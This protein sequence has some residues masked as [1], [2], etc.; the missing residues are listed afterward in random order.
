MDFRVNY[1]VVIFS[2]FFR[3]HRYTFLGIHYASLKRLN[4][5]TKKTV[6]G[7][8]S[9]GG[10]MKKSIALLFV[11]ALVAACSI[12][13]FGIPT[14]STIFK[15]NVI[16]DTYNATQ[17]ADEDSSLVVQGGILTLHQ[18]MNE[19]E[20]I[21]FSTD[22]VINSEI[23]EIGEISIDDPAPTGTAIALS[24]IDPN[25]SNGFVPAPGI[26]AFTMPVIL[27]D[28][29]EPLGEFQNV[30]V[31]SGTATLSFINNTVIWLGNINNGEPLVIRLLDSDGNEIL[32][33]TFDQDVPPDAAQTIT[34]TIDLAGEVLVNEIQMEMSGGSRGS[35]GQACTVDVDAMVNIEIEVHDLVVDDALAQI[36][37]QTIS[38][39]VDVTLDED[40]IIYEAEVAENGYQVVI[41]IENGIDVDIVATLSIDKLKLAGEDDYFSREIIIPASGGSG[42]VSTHTEVIAIGGAHLGNGTA[43]EVLQVEVEAVTIDTGD[44]YR[45]I[46]SQDAF[47]VEAVVE[48][49]DFASVTGILKPRAQEP[50]SG[51]TILDIEYPSIAGDFSI[52]GLSEITFDLYT[53]VPAALDIEVVGY[54]SNGEAVEMTEIASG[55]APHLDIPQGQSSVLFDSDTYNINEL[56]SILPDSISYTLYPV[57][58]DSLN[59]FSYEQGDAINA[60]IEIN[61]ELD[62]DADCWVIPKNDDGDP[63]IQVIETKDIEQQHIDAFQHGLLKVKYSNTLGVNAGTNILFSNQM[64]SGF[65][66][67]INPD[68]TQYTIIT[69]P[70]LQ[71]TS[72][73]QMGEIEVN[74][75]SHDLQYFVADSVFVVPK[76]RLISNEGTP[77]SGAIQLQASMQ[78][79]VEI[80][81]ELTD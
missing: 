62:I 23:V 60:D 47:D 32:S 22:P 25:L 8:S 49:L 43:F 16:N 78:I 55:N 35:D 75:T 54:N 58:G 45:Q 7:V 66:E 24:E 77:I 67:L 33:H 30:T 46:S 69:V 40:V 70:T 79:E 74:L 37:E 38:D 71:Q 65:N 39:T 13:D 61:A 44:D 4:R 34:Q 27:K 51:E 15:L 56:L 17:L 20:E 48:E 11:I 31:I 18:T 28:D 5:L 6:K 80:S 26:P 19:S 57:V 1:H 63:D 36:P 29:I 14:W 42:Q 64:A 21:E 59:V 76:I 73:T 10:V 81:N 41:D 2:S 52:S 68:T 72:G 12:P 9:T 50:V 53:P 3:T